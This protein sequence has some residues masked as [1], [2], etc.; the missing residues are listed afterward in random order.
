L[1]WRD[2]TLQ[3]LEDHG[4]AKGFRSKPNQ[5]LWSR[6][7]EKIELSDLSQIVRRHLKIRE[8][9]RSGEVRA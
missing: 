7:A 3:V 6:L 8:G 5:I 4:L 9:W 1:L 2:E